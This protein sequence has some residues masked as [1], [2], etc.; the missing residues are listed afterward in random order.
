MGAPPSRSGV[1]T[2]AAAA[3]GQPAPP[4]A[5]VAFAVL[6]PRGRRGVGEDADAPRAGLFSGLGAARTFDADA[7]GR[8]AH[9]K[10]TLADALR[11]ACAGVRVWVPPQQAGDTQ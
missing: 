11:D 10:A 8:G 4:T 3:A 2:G 1:T 5:A 6:R 9:A 7:L